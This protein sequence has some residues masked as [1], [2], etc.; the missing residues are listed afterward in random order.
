MDRQDF[1]LR[2]D[3]CLARVEQWLEDFDPDELDFTSADGVVKLEFAT[4]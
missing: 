4:G 1:H 2:A 3:A